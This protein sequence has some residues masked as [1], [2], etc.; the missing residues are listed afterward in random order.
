MD[1]HKDVCEVMR[2]D[3][4]GN[5]VKKERFKTSHRNIERFASSLS[6][7]DRVAL[8]SSTTGKMVYWKL[9]EA[10]INIH[11]AHPSDVSLIARSKSKTDEKDA[12]I[13]ANLLRMGYLP[14]S[15]VPDE[16]IEKIRSVVRLRVSLSQKM[17]AAKNQIHAILMRNAIEMKESDIFGKRGLRKLQ[18]FDL[19]PLDRAI[20][21]IHLKEVLL[22]SEQIEGVESIM[23]SMA[24]GIEEVK[25][26][27][28]IPG[29]SFYSALVIVGEV[30]DFHR[31]PSKKHLASYAGLVPSVRQSG[32]EIHTGH[33]TKRGPS[34][35]RWILVV[36]ANVAVRVA[37]PLRRLYLKLK[38]R[39]GHGKAIVAVAHKLLRIIYAMMVE[40]KEYDHQIERNVLRKRR[41]VR[42]SSSKMRDQ[43]L[44]ITIKGFTPE[45][46]E[47]VKKEVSLP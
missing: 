6:K 34:L 35:L 30:G 1:V 32:S 15:Y 40:G 26:L 5:V 7:D 42:R 36:C 33:I 12:A 45:V 27:M 3:E 17:T 23:A 47:R 22:L 46:L 16:H 43:D 28:T 24:E 38:D 20:L 44:S 14:E 18:S 13:L 11:M 2:L 19:P 9:K 10:G 4:N 25:L 41:E 31:F 39:K 8:E 29:V 37:G 21:D